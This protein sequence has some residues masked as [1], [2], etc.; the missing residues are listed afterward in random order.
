ME[1]NSELI[2]ITEVFQK[3]ILILR[4]FMSVIIAKTGHGLRLV[5]FFKNCNFKTHITRLIIE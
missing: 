4:S 3:N 5:S 1:R 2:E